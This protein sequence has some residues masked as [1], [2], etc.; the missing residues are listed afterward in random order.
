MEKSELI[1]MRKVG[2]SA[3]KQKTPSFEKFALQQ[4]G[5]LT[6]GAASFM[7]LE[8]QPSQRHLPFSLSTFF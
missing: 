8:V 2:H 4:F 7:R 1:S 5:S 3:S 6:Y